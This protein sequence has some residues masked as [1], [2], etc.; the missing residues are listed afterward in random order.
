MQE[1]PHANGL[2]TGNPEPQYASNGVN[3]GVPA[4]H[5]AAAPPT[6]R[7]DDL[8]SEGK[9]S[10]PELMMPVDKTATVQEGSEK[11]HRLGWKQ[12]TVCLIV[13]AIALGSLS[14]PSAFATLGMVPGVI[15]CVGL[16]L[17]AI[18]TSYVVGQVK[19]RY[20]H[21]NHYSDAVEIIWGKFGKELTGV[22]F[23]LFLILLVGSHALTGTIAFINIIGNYT[24]CALVWGVVSM[25]ILLVL[26]LPPTF[27]DF[28]FLGYIDFISIIAAILLTIIATGIQAH[29]APGGLSAVNWSAWPQPG[30]SF[31][32][33]FL[34]TTNIIFAY[35][36]AVC[37]FSFMSEMHT[38]K[39]YVK[40]I[41]ALGLIE[42]FIYTMT[43]AL[44]YAFVGQE[45]KSPALLSAGNTV[46]RIAF[47]IALPVIFISGS[48]NGTVVCRYI[49]DRIFP[50]SPIRFVKDVK[51]W[52]VWV[53]LITV[54]TVI[55]WIIA[56]AI[57][58]FNALLG[59]ISSLFISGFTFYW[60]ALFW[61]QLVKEGKWNANAKNI[62][63]SILNSIVF[64]I[65]LVV[66]GAGTYASVEDIITQYN[67]GAVRSPFTCS[68][69]S[70][71]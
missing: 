12:L 26:A 32:E 67:S 20:P 66:L 48:I 18:Y 24:T 59:L 27:H 35:S 29:D 19:M 21:V 4:R 16:G 51:G 52:G 31:Y 11:F 10:D 69:Q 1:V 14:I 54:V 64:V 3:T 42:I 63:L 17:V 2:T 50:T 36:F 53:G 13:E 6:Y 45:V 70:Y 49:M 62:S 30:T 33:A 43:G 47:G 22:M 25:I 5:Y 58:F 68:A 37:Q 60:P 61:F 28:A 46:S 7:L 57:P 71:A 44:I 39:D 56:E 23:A 41:W 40:S 34:A 9:K 15:M 8:S 38:P 55:G 65:G